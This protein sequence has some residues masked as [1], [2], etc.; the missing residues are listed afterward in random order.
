MMRVAVFCFLLSALGTAIILYNINFFENGVI[1]NGLDVELIRVTGRK[2]KENGLH[3]GSHKNGYGGDLELEDYR[4]IDP[5][6]IS[7]AVR[8]GPIQHGTPLM[9]YIPKPSPPNQPK[10]DMLPS[11]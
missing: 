9:P 3:S 11:P 7:K 1:I 8:P 10:H 2:L 6:P 5:V 4:A